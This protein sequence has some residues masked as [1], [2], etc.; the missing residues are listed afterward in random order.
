MLAKVLQIVLKVGG[1]VIGL[2]RPAVTNAD[3][4]TVAQPTPLA[5]GIQGLLSRKF[6]AMAGTIALTI[7]PQ[8]ISGIKEL[9]DWKV[10]ALVALYIV[11]NVVQHIG[12]ALVTAKYS[13]G[14]KGG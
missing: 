2:G 1:W 9:V 5:E 10:Y 6:L 3:G 11:A 7:L 8:L 4:S 12:M 14:A 13:D